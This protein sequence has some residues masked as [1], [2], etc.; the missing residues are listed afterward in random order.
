MKTNNMNTSINENVTSL[1]FIE[2]WK[3]FTQ[4]IGER[5][6]V[7]E[8]LKTDKGVT[9]LIVGEKRTE[10]E[11]S[12]LGDF[13]VNF[14]KRIN[15]SYIKED[16]LFDL[17]V[18]YKET[19]QNLLSYDVDESAKELRKDILTTNAILIEHENNILMSYEEMIKLTYVKARLKVI[20]TYDRWNDGGFAKMRLSK[21]LHQI[22]SQANKLIPE[23]ELTEYLIIIGQNN[24]DM[25]TWYYSEHPYSVKDICNLMMSGD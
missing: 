24:G 1:S 16:A 3:E 21:N 19:F 8:A 12:T 22:V 2:L 17:S 6:D 15:L 20:I 9:H 13:I 11:N 7:K 10:K 18:Y 14:Y 23:Y 5:V 4:K 25:I